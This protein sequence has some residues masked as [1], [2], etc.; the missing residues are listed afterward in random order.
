MRVNSC[1][2]YTP[3]AYCTTLYAPLVSTE[4]DMF[5][6]PFSSI[7]LLMR[8]FLRVFTVVKSKIHG[9]LEW[10][11]GLWDALYMIN[12]WFSSEFASLE[13][14]FTTLPIDLCMYLSRFE[15]LN[16]WLSE[17]LTPLTQSQLNETNNMH[18]SIFANGK[19]TRIQLD[20]HRTQTIPSCL[21]IKSIQVRSMSVMYRSI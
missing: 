6:P 4:S 11:R 9:W 12:M 10:S 2:M 1:V 5:C 3:R 18:S 13:P 14:E 21:F 7:H 16:F 17:R 19:S 15:L 20:M 8:L